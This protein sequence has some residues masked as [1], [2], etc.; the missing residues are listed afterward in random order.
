MSIE[1]VDYSFS[2][3]SPAALKAAGKHFAVRYGGPGSASKQ[4]TK[5][6]YAALKAAGIEVVANAE[7][8]AA[9]F[10][11]TAAGK[12]WAADAEAY[13]KSVGMPSGR[14]IYF[15][16]DWDADSGDWSAID[17]A[18]RGAASVIGAGCVGVYGSYDVMQHC[19]SAGTA[20]WFWQTYAWSG[21]KAPSSFVHLYQYH[22]G[23]KIGGADCDLTRAL[24]ADYGQWG[25]KAPAPAAGRKV[26]YVKIDGN[27]P[28]LK[29]G[30]N[31]PLPGTTTNYVKRAQSVLAWI[32]G[33]E[34]KIDGDYGPKM[35]A[36][37][38]SMM[39]DDAARSSAN[40]ATFGLPEWRRAYGI[41]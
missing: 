35:S 12:S 4:I 10:K 7:G 13:F 18:L 30:D 33:Y 32:G 34:G 6:E 2:R 31:D 15:S 1:G 27:L 25:Y 39:K 3:P 38:K 37:V 41:W 16:V 14:P 29:S 24:I 17:A 11:G 21:G 8:A 36:A 5:S 23:V 19:H 20:K 28:V 26:T 22:N 9:G 40:G